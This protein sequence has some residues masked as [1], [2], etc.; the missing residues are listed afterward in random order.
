MSIAARQ[1]RGAPAPATHIP[2]RPPS[3]RE[4]VAGDRA[5][6]R[7]CAFSTWW[8]AAIDEVPNWWRPSWPMPSSH[9]VTRAG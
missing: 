2:E 1:A 8:D 9:W 5:R 6:L 7:R 4:V 3:G